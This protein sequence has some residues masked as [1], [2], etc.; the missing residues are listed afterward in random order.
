M[1]FGQLVECNTRNIYLEKPYEKCGG[2][3]TPR[4]FS[5]KL[6]LRIYLDQ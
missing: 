3:T 5:K 4:P 1:K 6:K 2:V